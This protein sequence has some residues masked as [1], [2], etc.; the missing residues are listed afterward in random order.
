MAKTKRIQKR[1]EEDFPLNSDEAYDYIIGSIDFFDMM[2]GGIDSFS[3]Y[4]QTQQGHYMNEMYEKIK[5]WR[6][7]KIDESL[8]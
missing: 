6:Q 8:R 7:R 4:I 1:V 3:A 5:E 2:A